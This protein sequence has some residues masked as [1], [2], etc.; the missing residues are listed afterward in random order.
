MILSKQQI[1]AYERDGFIVVEGVLAGPEVSE[2]RR[3]TD[4]LHRAGPAGD[5][6]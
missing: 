6:A 5:R 1:E 2:L 4:E 3:V